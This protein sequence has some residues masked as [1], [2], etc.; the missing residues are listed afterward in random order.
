ME[1]C[2]RCGG[3]L[4]RHK[5]IV[6]KASW[7]LDVEG[8]ATGCQQLTTVATYASCSGD[9]ASPGCGFR[10]VIDFHRQ[11]AQ[12]RLFTRICFN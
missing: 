10:E 5:E 8:V 12:V 1:S 2:P 3:K 4:H 7:R 9:P 11:E 6:R